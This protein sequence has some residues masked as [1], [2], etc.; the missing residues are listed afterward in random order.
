MVPMAAWFALAMMA[1][2]TVL[3]TFVYFFTLTPC[4]EFVAI[5]TFFACITLTPAAN[6]KKPKTQ[7]QN[8]PVSSKKF[9]QYQYTALRSKTRFVSR[10]F[11]SDYAQRNMY[12][13]WPPLFIVLPQKAL[14]FFWCSC[15]E[16]NKLEFCE[17]SQHNNYN[18]DIRMSQREHNAR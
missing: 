18:P 17:Y 4:I 14:Q 12:R 6:T 5:V 15:L 9:Y 7:D 8:T 1:L 10:L 3:I 16:P 2:F 11:G 13:K